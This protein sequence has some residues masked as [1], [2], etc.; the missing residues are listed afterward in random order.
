MVSNLPSDGIGSRFRKYYVR[1]LQSASNQSGCSVSGSQRHRRRGLLIIATHGKHIHVVHDC[2]YSGG[3]CRCALTERLQNYPGQVHIEENTA[4]L[5]AEDQFYA[6]KSEYEATISGSGPIRLRRRGIVRLGFGNSTSTSKTASC[7]AADGDRGDGGL[8]RY[9]RRH[10]LSSGLS[11][12]Y[13]QNLS[14]YLYGKGRRVA[15]YEV[16]GRNWV[17]DHQV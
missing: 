5:E 4:W 7:R 10:M 11:P 16:A 2:N 15:Y 12:S 17:F 9:S 1:H 3:S 8:R 14:E 6:Q 13:F